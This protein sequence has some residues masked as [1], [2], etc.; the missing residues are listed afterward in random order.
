MLTHLYSLISSIL[1]TRRPT[2]MPSPLQT[3]TSKIRASHQHSTKLG[4]RWANAIWN[5]KIFSRTQ[6]DLAYDLIEVNVR[7]EDAVPTSVNSHMT[8]T[9][10]RMPRCRTRMALNAQPRKWASANTSKW[11]QI[12][13]GVTTEQFTPYSWTQCTFQTLSSLL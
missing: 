1:Q 2:Q 6:L 12:T 4:N 13:S 7:W 5:Q 3:S 9:A 8:E 10:H 11:F